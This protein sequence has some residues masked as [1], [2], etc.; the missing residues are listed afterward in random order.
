M[1]HLTKLILSLS[2]IRICVSVW[3]KSMGRDRL[4]MVIGKDAAAISDR[5]DIEYNAVESECVQ[6]GQSS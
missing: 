4:P 5:I 3:M 2:T 1:I 6:Q